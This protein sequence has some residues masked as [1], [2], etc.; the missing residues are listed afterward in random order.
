MG[1]KKSF[2]SQIG[3]RD[4]IELGSNLSISFAS[5]ELWNLPRSVEA[6]LR[7]KKALRNK[8]DAKRIARTASE[9]DEDATMMHKKIRQDDEQ[10][11]SCG[12]ERL[13]HKI[14]RPFLAGARLV[15]RCVYYRAW[16]SSGSMQV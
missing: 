4:P 11:Q 3:N 2:F 16:L 7:R 10:K 1:R 12:R 6:T 14:T 13:E 8:N 15:G 9:G 5:T